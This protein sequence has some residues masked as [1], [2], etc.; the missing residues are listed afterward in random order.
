MKPQVT[1][2][3]SDWL[4]SLSLFCSRL[5]SLTINRWVT[6]VPFSSNSAVC[7]HIA[8][9]AATYISLQLFVVALKVP[10]VLT[11]SLTKHFRTWTQQVTSQTRE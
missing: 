1:D 10:S 3:S 11:H 6:I 5:S 8:N 4:H 9:K 7:R 2:V